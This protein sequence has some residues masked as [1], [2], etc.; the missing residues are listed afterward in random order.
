MYY[1]FDFIF[2]VLCLGVFI[3]FCELVYSFTI[4]YL[5]CF[6]VLLPSKWFPDKNE[7]LKEREERAWKKVTVYSV[8]LILLFV[9]DLWV[10]QISDR[11][12]INEAYI[13]LQE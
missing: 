12:I 7:N 10:Y 13:K 4:I 8:F 1:L 5:N 9:F 11:S 6:V 3:A 2:I